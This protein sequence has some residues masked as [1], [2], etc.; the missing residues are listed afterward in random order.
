[1]G[2]FNPHL[3][4]GEDLDLWSR[5]AMRF[6]SVAYSP[7]VCWRCWLD[8]TSSLTRVDYPRDEVLSNICANMRASQSLG[9]DVASAYYPY[10]RKRAISYILR[11]A[12]GRIDI[13]REAL[14]EA[15]TVFPPSYKERTLETVLKVL[16][17]SV[18]GKIVGRL[19]D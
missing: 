3:S 19:A 14:C 7:D 2:V 1:V 5:I 16:P 6:P 4:R 12:A 17:T 15:K 10:G 9:P 11:A 13:E 18:A 8:S